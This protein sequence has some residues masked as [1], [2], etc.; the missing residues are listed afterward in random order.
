[1]VIYHWLT[2]SLLRGSG[3]KFLV[4]FFN[5]HPRRC[6]LPLTREWIE[7]I[8]FLY[9]SSSRTFSLLR[10]S[11]LKFYCQISL[12]IRYWFS[13]L[14]GSGLKFTE[15]VKQQPLGT[16]LP[17]TREWIEIIRF[18][19]KPNCSW[20]SPSY[21]GVDWNRKQIWVITKC[22]IVLPLT[23]EW[24]EIVVGVI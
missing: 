13:L 12:H 19:P 8:N 24:I 18:S 11:G 14:R 16:V 17:L 15:S 4:S 10:G 21:E 1:M 3:L 6:V 9:L 20:S 2:F 22:Y 5:S 23:R 7:I